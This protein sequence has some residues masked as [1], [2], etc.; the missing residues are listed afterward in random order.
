MNLGRRGQGRVLPTTPWFGLAVCPLTLFVAVQGAESTLATLI[1]T[2]LVQFG[3]AEGPAQPPTEDPAQPEH[4]RLILL[5]ALP[6]EGAENE[7]LVTISSVRVDGHGAHHVPVAP[8]GSGSAPGNALDNAQ[9]KAPDN[10]RK[11]AGRRDWAGGV[12]GWAG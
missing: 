2:L 4:A 12:W 8:A 7:I 3:V 11:V 1:L 9:G 5:E 10:A 6:S